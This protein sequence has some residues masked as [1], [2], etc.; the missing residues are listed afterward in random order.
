MQLPPT[1]L[2][3]DKRRKQQSKG[4]SASSSKSQ[5]KTSNGKSKVKPNLAKNAPPIRPSPSDSRKDE[6]NTGNG[7]GDD[8][9]GEMAIEDSKSPS[10]PDSGT[11]EES[12]GN[13]SDDDAKS[14]TVVANN[15]PRS[16]MPIL[17]PSRSLET[18]LFDRL[19]S[20]YGS[21]IKRMLNIQYRCVDGLAFPTSVT[22]TYLSGCT[23][24]SVHFHPGPSTRIS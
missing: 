21:G 1:V 24:K 4:A 12:A 18:T 20:M 23:I 10:T 22:Y 2:S 8:V 5:P 17:R 6:E 14:E 15:E 7:S 16:K 13:G 3:L 11:E 19:E 9:K